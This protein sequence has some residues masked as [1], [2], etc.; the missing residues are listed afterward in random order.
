MKKFL[1]TESEK[2]RILGMHYNAMGK[3]LVNEEVGDPGTINAV[4]REQEYVDKGMSYIGLDYYDENRNRKA[5]YYHCTPYVYSTKETWNVPGNR[6]GD[7]TDGN[8]D[9]I[10]TAAKLGLKGDYNTQLKNACQNI[11]TF[12]NNYKK[13]FCANPKNKT[14]DTY[15]L[16]CPQETPQPQVA[17]AT[18]KV[19][20]PN[21]VSDADVAATQKREAEVK[22]KIEQANIDLKKLMDTPRFLRTTDSDGYAITDK[23]TLDAQVKEL[24]R[25]LTNGAIPTD[26][27]DKQDLLRSMNNVIKAFPEY[28]ETLKS[29][30]YQLQ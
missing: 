29:Y 20:A 9:F 19:T 11:Y 26:R 6:A 12:Y 21:P 5:Y 15:V 30:I 1:M 22:A 10:G 17:A 16:L 4:E 23:T 13:T 28:G 27:I 7:F 2:S 14:K 18:T 24:A 8:G 3:S 25:V